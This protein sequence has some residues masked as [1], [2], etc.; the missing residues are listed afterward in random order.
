MTTARRSPRWGGSVKGCDGRRPGVGDSPE[1]AVHQVPG[2]PGVGVPSDD[3]R[4]LARV[5]MAVVVH[6]AILQAQVV[7]ILVPADHRPLV[8]VLGVGGGEQ[9]LFHQTQGTVHAPKFALAD[10]YLQLRG[11]GVVVQLQVQQAIRLQ[12]EAQLQ[13]LGGQVFEVRGII[14]GGEGVDLPAPGLEDA[15]ELFGSPGFRPPEHQVFEEVGDA[16]DPRQFVPGAHMIMELQGDDG[17]TGVGQDQKGEAIIQGVLHQVDSRLPGRRRELGG[18][19]HRFLLRIFRLPSLSR[20]GAY[21][22][23]DQ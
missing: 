22:M 17:E 14:P 19:G 18:W 3:H 16:G 11:E 4:Q 2:P 6:Q 15:G 5:V 12:L 8:G 13:V 23:S 1:V 20:G 9:F 10:Y 7:Q 21:K